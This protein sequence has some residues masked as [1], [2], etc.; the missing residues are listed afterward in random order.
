MPTGTKS[1]GALALAT[2]AAAAFAGAVYAQSPSINVTDQK[3]T[4][5][6]VTIADVNLPKKGFVAIHA[7]DAS[8]NMNN[9]IVGYAAL[10]AGDH[11]GVKVRLTGAHKAGETLWV[12]AHETKGRYL[13]SRRKRNI[14]APF[15]QDGKI[16]DQSFKTL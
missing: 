4:R 16:V 11:K 14:G 9:K 1:I 13:G 7:S 3:P 15:T 8:G 10:R 12:V 6:T 2:V 5:N